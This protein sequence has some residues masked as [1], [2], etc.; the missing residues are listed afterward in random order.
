MYGATEA[1]PRVTIAEDNGRRKNFQTIGKPLSN[2][3]LMIIKN[4]KIID[5]PHI[6]GTVFKI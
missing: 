1:G 6:T 3:K 2:Y 5:K 4:N